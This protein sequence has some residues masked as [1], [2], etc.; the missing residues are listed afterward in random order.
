MGGA[1]AQQ[2]GGLA[3]PTAEREKREQYRR[4]IAA[5]QAAGLDGYAEWAEGI[6][7]QEY[8]ERGERYGRTE[9]EVER[10]S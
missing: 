4:T 7:R 9:E 8:R 3:R 10:W 5:R 2:A 6:E 1:Y